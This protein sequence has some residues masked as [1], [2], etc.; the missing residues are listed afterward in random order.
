MKIDLNIFNSVIFGNLRPNLNNL[1]DD[2]F[3]NVIQQISISEKYTSINDFNKIFS[4]IIAKNQLIISDDNYKLEILTDSETVNEQ[5]IDI[6]EPLI[7][8]DF[9]KYND[10]ILEYYKFILMNDTTKIIGTYNKA[11]NLLN[12]Q[13]EYY[14]NELFEQLDN[15]SAI[16]ENRLNENS[17][18]EKTITIFE[19][20]RT[21]ILRI[22]VEIFS[23]FPEFFKNAD[24]KI[25]DS[26]N[27]LNKF[28]FI[29]SKLNYVKIQKLINSNTFDQPKAT[30]LIDKIRLDYIHFSEI[31]Q[32]NRQLIELNELQITNIHLL[33]E[34]IFIQNFNFN[35]VEI[36]FKQPLN[37][38]I[39]TK[40][41]DEYRK[42]ILVQL[43]KIPHPAQRMDCIYTEISKFSFLESSHKIEN[44][45]LD[46]SLPRKLRKWLYEI[47]EAWKV[48]PNYIPQQEDNIS[49]IQ[50]QPRVFQLPEGFKLTDKDIDE[51]IDRL[52][53]YQTALLF[54]YLKKTKA[55]IEYSD[56][57]LAKF[58]YYLT[59]HSEQKLRREKGFGVIWN[60]IQ[61]K[62]KNMDYQDIENYNLTTLKDLLNEIIDLINK[63]IKANN[64]NPLGTPVPLRSIA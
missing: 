23:I 42:T 1:S 45:R 47:K 54:H 38:V 50:N 10:P 2:K 36:S 25:A 13:Q 31:P 4:T 20:L 7:F 24:D 11:I 40:I 49:N 32:V 61:D 15:Y 55:I 60:I 56:A 34:Y 39:I 52:D 58:V 35:N 26:F 8:I 62:A 18:D 51:K 59:G 30:E 19:I 33:E 17:L 43:D 14:T 21:C 27:K 3:K 5:Y 53:I 37:P 46:F 9:P 63:E 6:F 44:P 16:I 22:N 48:N 41:S 28:Q 12:S 57:S 29:T 64:R